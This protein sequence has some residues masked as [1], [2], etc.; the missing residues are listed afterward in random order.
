MEGIW[1]LVAL[2]G[3]AVAIPLAAVVLV[4]V[5][6]RREEAFQ[7]LSGRPPGAAAELARRLLGYRSDIEFDPVSQRSRISTRYVA[8]P[9]SRRTG[10]RTGQEVLFGYARRTL[11]GTGKY[12]A[13]RQPRPGADSIDR[14]QTAGV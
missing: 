11:P 5:A 3:A 1:I 8:P 10:R 4:T 13:S 6:S 14:R 7:S 9:A 12:A 2:V